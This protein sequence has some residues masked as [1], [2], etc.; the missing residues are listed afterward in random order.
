MASLPGVA[1][2][3]ALFVGIIHTGCGRRFMRETRPLIAHMSV[4][5]LLWSVPKVT[6]FV[7]AS[8]ARVFLRTRRCPH[9]RL[10][11]TRYES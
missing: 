8:A 4:A 1:Y 7:N 6:G 11:R 10:V 3:R 5:E 9:M 2:V